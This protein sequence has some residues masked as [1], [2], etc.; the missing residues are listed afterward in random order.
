MLAA[1]PGRALPLTLF[2]SLLAITGAAAFI[3]FLRIA[4]DRSW[5]AFHINFVFWSGTAFGSVLLAA[6]LDICNARWGRPIKRLAEAPGAFLPFAFLLFWLIYAGRER[7]FPWIHEPVPEKEAWLN[8]SSFF[9]RDGLVMALLTGTAMLLIYHSVRRDT[10]AVAAND[11]SCGHPEQPDSHTRAT[12]ILAPLYAVLFAFLLT[13][14][15]IDLVMSLDPHWYSTLFGAYFFMGSFYTGLTVLMILMVFAV[16]SMRMS[17]FIMPR[18]FHD[19]GKLLL[20]FGLMTG[21]FFYVQYMVMWYGNLPEE[22]VY[23]IERIRILPWKPLA[24]LV[25]II[26]FGIPFVVLLN[27][28]VKMKP[29]AML[30]LGIV[31]L[32]GMWLER[33]MLIA[34]AIWKKEDLPLGLIEAL[35]TAGFF[36]LMG[37]CILGFLKRFPVFP[38]SDPLFW[39]SIEEQIKNE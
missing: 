4:P 22:T 34:P 36:G 28:K 27:R 29:L 30:V 35:I 8:V 21:D 9:I 12:R 17:E 11:F 39:E 16:R 37:L 14:L 18:Q 26:A 5:Q 10:R 33:F 3:I 38:V 13:I 1:G 23:I 2:F 15:G 19:M 25:L 24:P 7:I 6:I 20:G 32:S 31:I